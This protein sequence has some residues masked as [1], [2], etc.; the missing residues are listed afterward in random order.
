M[1][2]GF[3]F[4]PKIAPFVRQFAK[5]P[6]KS[7]TGDRWK[8][9]AC[10]LHAGYLRLQTHTQNMNYLLFSH[11]NKFCTNAP[12]CYVICNI[13]WLLCFS[14]GRFQLFA[15]SSAFLQESQSSPRLKLMEIFLFYIIHKRYVAWFLMMVFFLI[16][17]RSSISVTKYCV[18]EGHTK[19]FHGKFS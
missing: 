7:Q 17:L 11:C 14:S 12:Q 18:S 5:K 10:A 6:M 3:I 19:G 4:F 13:D 9:S 2:N 16:R 1:C 15:V 8:Y